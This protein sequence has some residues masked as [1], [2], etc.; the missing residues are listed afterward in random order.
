MRGAMLGKQRKK[1]W[2]PC[3]PYWIRGQTSASNLRWVSHHPSLNLYAVYLNQI[4]GDIGQVL[5]ARVTDT[6]KAVQT[7]A[8]DVVARIAT[9]MGK[10]FEKHTRFFALPVATVLADQKAPI[11]AA[12]IQ[13]LTAIATACEGVDSMVPG[14]TT[15]LE[16]TNPTQ[17][18]SLLSWIRDW[19]GEHPPSSSLDLKD[20]AGSVVSCLDDRNA[21]ARKAAQAVLPTVVM[22]AGFDHVMHQTASLKPASRATAVPLIQAARANAQANA[23]TPAAAPTKTSKRPPVI[24]V[25]AAASSPPESP[26]DAPSPVVKAASAKATGVRRKLPA[27]TASRPESRAEDVARGAGK[28]GLGASK[29]GGAASNSARAAQ[30]PV[31]SNLPFLGMNIEAKK[32]RLGKDANRWINDAGPTRKDLAE[33]LQHQMETHVSKDLIARLFSHDHNAVNDYVSGLVTMADF[34]SSAQA[35][36]SAFGPPEDVRAAALANFDLALKYISI[37]AHEPQS[38]LISKGLDVVDAVVGFLSSVDYHL[39]DAEAICFIPTMVY[40]VCHPSNRPMINCSL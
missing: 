7:L 26:V 14:L 9:G 31:A 36:D 3:K 24:S 2:R 12:A 22:C 39:T 6:N 34:Y 25:P 30:S 20:W 15:A 8:L 19:F 16:S 5:K 17:K 27:G 29:Q 35:E 13:T 33:L 10:P 37:K 4:L 23:P 18:A 32:A 11:R 21:E 38:N 28:P 40:K 1:P